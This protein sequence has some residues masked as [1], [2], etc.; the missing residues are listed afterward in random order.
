MD[1]SCE[2]PT[3]NVRL[4]RDTL[5]VSLVNCNYCDGCKKGQK[6]TQAELGLN[7]DLLKDYRRI[8]KEGG[9]DNLF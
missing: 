1:K 8:K 4:N 6:M 5:I 3:R 7:S 9:F 2:K